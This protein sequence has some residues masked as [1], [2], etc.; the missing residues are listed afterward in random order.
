MAQQMELLKGFGDPQS[1][2]AQLVAFEHLFAV[3]L[4]GDRCV[5]LGGGGVGRC[6]GLALPAVPQ[7]TQEPGLVQCTGVC[8]LGSQL[9]PPTGSPTR[10]WL[11]QAE[12]GGGGAEADVRRG[13]GG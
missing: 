5:C 8:R 2:L 10:P 6:A 1:Q 7:G 4:G 12:G 13:P 3:T 11:A 9:H